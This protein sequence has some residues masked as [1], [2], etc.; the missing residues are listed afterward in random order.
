[1]SSDDFL[2][3]ASHII[4]INALHSTLSKKYSIKRLGEP[5]QYLG[6]TIQHGQDGSVKISQPTYVHSVLEH[7]R[8]ETA[9]RKSPPTP[10]E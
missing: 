4:L 10:T 8:M 3:V 9:N 6:W 7:M 2:V 1:M 5:T